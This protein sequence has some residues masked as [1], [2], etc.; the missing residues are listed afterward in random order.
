VDAKITALQPILSTLGQLPFEP[1]T[2]KGWDGGRQWINS[3][4]LL[5]RTAFAADLTSNDEYGQLFADGPPFDVTDS[6]TTARNCASL[7]L[8][9][10]PSPAMVEKLKLYLDRAAGGDRIKGLTYLVLT[11]P[12]YQL[13]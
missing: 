6:E 10:D 11:A 3:A 1:P 8:G 4:T 5:T 9:Q 2:V 13:M 7:L 12:E